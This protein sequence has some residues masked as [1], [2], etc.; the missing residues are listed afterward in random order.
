MSTSNSTNYATSASAIISRALRMIGAISQGESPTSDQSSEA[1]IA[2]NMLCKSLEADGM[3]L[4]AIKQT[5]ITLTNAVNTYNIG[6]GQTV[7]INKPLKVIVC[8]DF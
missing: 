5:N 1:M 6:V 4:W 3:P 2:L 8:P 7:N